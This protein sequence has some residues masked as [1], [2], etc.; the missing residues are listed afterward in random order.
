M[1]YQLHRQGFFRKQLKP[2]TTKDTEKTEDFSSSQY[3]SSKLYVSP[4]T[5]KGFQRQG[6][7]QRWDD[8]K[9]KGTCPASEQ[10][11]FKFC[12]VFVFYKIAIF[13]IYKWGHK[14]SMVTFLLEWSLSNP[15]TKDILP[16]IRYKRLHNLLIQQ[17]NSMQSF[18]TGSLRVHERI[19]FFN[20]CHHF[21]CQHTSI[22]KWVSQ[23]SWVKVQYLDVGKSVEF[24]L[25]SAT[26]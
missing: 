19:H 10:H 2:E 22:F 6:K 8:L 1:H 15:C 24:K 5:L 16:H 26:D 14:T 18:N 12:L 11:A 23:K 3:I 7:L 25:P 20:Y 4:E 17:L 9:Q 21:I 13:P